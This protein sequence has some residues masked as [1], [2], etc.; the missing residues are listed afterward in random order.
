MPDSA[1]RQFGLALIEQEWTEIKIN[2]S[3][4]KQ[5]A[6]MQNILTSLIDMHCPN[7]TVKLIPQIDEP[8]ITNELKMF[9]MLDRQRKIDY[10]KHSKSAKYCFLNDLF[11]AKY[12]RASKDYMEK[13]MLEES[14]NVY[15]A[16]ALIR[17]K[18]TYEHRMGPNIF[19]L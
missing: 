8:F 18:Q 7:K 16:F 6:T 9:K 13:M 17:H 15:S 19:H 11:M 14:N 4:E 12:S 2:E 1:V 5:E 3:S 10:R